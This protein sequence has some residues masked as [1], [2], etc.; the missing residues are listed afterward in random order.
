VL[1]GFAFGFEQAV[2]DNPVEGDQVYVDAPLAASVVT[3]PKQ[4]IFAG[5]PLITGLAFTVTV[6]TPVSIQPLASVPVTI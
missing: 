6:I 2:Q 5:P 3:A 1:A 4:I